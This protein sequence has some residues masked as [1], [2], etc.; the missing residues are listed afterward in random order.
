MMFT[1]KATIAL[2]IFASMTISVFSYADAKVYSPNFC[3]RRGT[4]TT[5]LS[6]DYNSLANTTT[7]AITVQCPAI[8][9]SQ[10]TSISSAWIQVYD[11]SST[12]DVNCILGSVYQS[13]TNTYYVTGPGQNSSGSPMYWQ[14]LVFPSLT[15]YNSYAS[16]YLSC[17]IPAISGTLQSSLGNYMINE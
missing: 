1:K 10:T 9:D 7:G 6:Q 17:T 16:I 8:N 12:A 5:G 2:V 13:T 14:Q 11:L 15:M 3:V 4:G